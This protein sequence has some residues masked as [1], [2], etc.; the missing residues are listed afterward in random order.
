MFRTLFLLRQQGFGNTAKTPNYIFQIVEHVRPVRPKISASLTGSAGFHPELCHQLRAK[1]GRVPDKPCIRRERHVN[2]PF[3]F[4][5]TQVEV[6]L[7]ESR[8]TPRHIMKL[9]TGPPLPAPQSTLKAST[10]VSLR[11]FSP[12]AQV[13]FI[14]LND[15]WCDFPP[16]IVEHNV[17][18]DTSFQ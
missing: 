5:E 17:H 9:R 14:M 3:K 2:T 10:A 6:L 18:T 13:V 7:Q 8:R 12:S 1:Y 15:H 11:Y 4:S 16:V